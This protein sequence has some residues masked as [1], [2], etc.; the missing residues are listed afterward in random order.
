MN[1]YQIN[2]ILLKEKITATVYQGVFSADAIPVLP[3]NS[4]AVVNR[5][6]S[7]QPGSHWMAIYIDENGNLEFFDSYG[8]SPFFYGKLIQDY[9]SKYSNVIWNS[10]TFQSITSNVCGH[11][12]IYFILK[13]CQGNSMYFIIQNLYQNKRNDFQIFQ[14]VKK[15]YGIRMSFKK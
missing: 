10:V 2:K 15:K 6:D 3:P 1:G 7:S 14:F 12:C 13:R 5:D 8:Q 9:V 11:Y 4:A